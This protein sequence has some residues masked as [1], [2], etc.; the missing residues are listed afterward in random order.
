MGIYDKYFRK[1]IFVSRIDKVDN[2]LNPDYLKAVISYNMYG[3]YCVPISAQ[4]R[5]LGQ[6]ILRGDVFEPDTIA[7]MRSNIKDGDIIHAG[8]FFG[9]FLP[10]LSKSLAPDAKIWAFEPNK[11]NFQCAEVTLMLNNINNVN[12]YPYGLGENKSKAVL[13][14]KN[15]KGMAL[16]GSSTI[17]ETSDNEDSYEEVNIVTIDGHIPEDRNINIL[18]LDVEGFEE[19][20]LKGA[21][22]TIQRCRPI[23]ILEDDKGVT[24]SQWFEKN[25]L[26]LDYKV[27]DKLHYNRIVMPIE[28]RNK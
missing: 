5:T 28:V 9:D 8:T 17:I 19:N 12:L 25:V 1:K 16:G 24:R 27:S 13:K 23:I 7:Y 10:G 4:H 14:T 3:A 15:K 11:E 21:L 2:D 26:S 6:K 22:K 20:A 18:Q